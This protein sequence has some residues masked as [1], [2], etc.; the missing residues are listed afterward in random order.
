[1]FIGVIFYVCF[2]CRSL[3]RPLG[4]GY[5][6]LVFLHIWLYTSD[7]KYDGTLGPNSYA[8]DEYK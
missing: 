3:I 2:P 7:R 6:Q 1:M 5:L 4:T 8:D